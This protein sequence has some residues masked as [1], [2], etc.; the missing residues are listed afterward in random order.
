MFILADLKKESNLSNLLN[1]DLPQA[2]ACSYVL[3]M[4]DKQCHTGL[5]IMF[6]LIA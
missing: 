3:M 6:R 4:R 1:I 5:V 2:D